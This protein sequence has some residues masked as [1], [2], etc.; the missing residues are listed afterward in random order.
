MGQPQQQNRD[1]IAQLKAELEELNRLEEV[2]TMKEELARKRAAMK[3]QAEARAAIP[4]RD[5]VRDAES[6]WVLIVSGNEEE[7]LGMSW[8]G[9][10]VPLKIEQ[11]MVTPL[12]DLAA[13]RIE[14]AVMCLVRGKRGQQPP[15]LQD[16]KVTDQGDR[17]STPRS[18]AE[19]FAEMRLTQAVLVRDHWLAGDGAARFTG[20]LDSGSFCSAIAALASPYGTRFP[21]VASAKNGELPRKMV[22]RLL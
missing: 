14:D 9:E 2:R 20:S 19:L 18:Q 7:Q 6:T 12:L 5:P 11:H 4:D 15:P 8:L 1:E 16:T 10:H 17:L 22:L 3:A 13:L 21:E